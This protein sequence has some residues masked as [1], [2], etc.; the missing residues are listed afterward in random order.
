MQLPVDVFESFV[1]DMGV[2]LGG[3]QIRMPEHQLDTAQI[4]TVCQKMGR[5][6]VAQG[7]GRNPLA[8]PGQ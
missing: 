7:M 1:S 8:D 5:K 4:G 3:C 6:G 2:N